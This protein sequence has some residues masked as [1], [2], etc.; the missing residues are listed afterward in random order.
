MSIVFANSYFCL[1]LSDVDT[2]LVILNLQ[3]AHH[4]YM[5]L[6]MFQD[7][8]NSYLTFLLRIFKCYYSKEVQRPGVNTFFRIVIYYCGLL[9]CF[10]EIMGAVQRMIKLVSLLLF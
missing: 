4:K 9:L 6:C 3:S 1:L 8:T 7:L 5:T 10:F 2:F